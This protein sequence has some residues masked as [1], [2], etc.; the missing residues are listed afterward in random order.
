MAARLRIVEAFHPL[1]IR[2]AGLGR[3]LPA[4][5][6]SAAELDELCGMPPGWTLQRTG[7]AERRWASPG[8]TAISLGAQAAREALDEAGIGPDGIDLLLNASGTPHQT[9]PDNAPMILDALGLGG[10]G[11]PGY[12]IHSTCLS[13]LPALHLAARLIGAG[14]NRT[15]L[16]VSSDIA[17]RGLNFAEP[18]S[19][20][21]MGDAAAA[22]V[23]TWSETSLFEGFHMETYGQAHE[24]S[25]IRGGG[26]GVH[27]NHPDTRPEQNLFS[28]RGKPLAKLIANR[29]PAFFERLRPGLSAGLPGIDHVVPHQTSKLGL[30]LLSR[31]GWPD[32][33]IVKTLPELGNCV[34]ASIPA[35]LYEGVR[36]GR[37]QRGQ[38]VLLV[39]SGAGISLAGVILRF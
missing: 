27:P 28:M 34:A 10:S 25:G 12:S 18:E 1:P 32:E 23:V 3:A 16:I 4:R 5:R 11:I 38:R 7:V 30:K 31:F 6:V 8:E 14:V 37:I 22:A 29:L 21:L 33:Q 17:S 35:T 20:A 36:S 15:V 26:T 39:G 24:L 2:I 9:I 19:A 13:F